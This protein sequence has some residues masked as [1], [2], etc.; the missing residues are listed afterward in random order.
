VIEIDDQPP[1][2]VRKRTPTAY[3]K[4]SFPSIKRASPPGAP[5]E[6]SL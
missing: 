3:G 5:D 6:I 1:C 4:M 2:A